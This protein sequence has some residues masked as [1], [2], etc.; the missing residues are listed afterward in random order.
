MPPWLD[1][2][3]VTMLRLNRLPLE[4]VGA[5]VIDMT[6]GMELPPGVYDQIIRKS[7]GVP[8]FVEELTKTVLASGPLH[9]AGDR[10]IALGPLRSFAIPETL[11]DSLIARLDRLVSIKE[12]AQIDAAL[13]REFSYRLLAAVAPTAGP[14]LEAALAQLGAA[15]LIFARGEPPD[16]TY[17]FKHA[18]VQEAAYASVLHS[19]RLQLH[20]Q[21][22]DALKEH[23][24]EIIESHPELMAHHLAEAGLPE[25]AIEYL[26]KAGERAI[27]RSANVEAI[28]HLKRAL[29]LFQSLFDH[30]ARTHK[31]LELV[32]LLGQAMIAGHGSMRLRRPRKFSYGPRR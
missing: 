24:L 3:H 20:G 19:K 23:F 26:K 7:D 10:Y 14:R 18:L 1:H 9:V 15:E 12:I 31:A 5:M 29:K 8:L 22:A 27:L 25:R 11:H 21:I 2:S 6:N 17:V 30:Q 16:S 28:S 4:Q 13:G 32:V